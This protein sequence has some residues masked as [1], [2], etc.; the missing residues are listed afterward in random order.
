MSLFK[1]M[2]PETTDGKSRI[3]LEKSDTAKRTLVSH[4]WTDKTT[5]YQDATRVVD[6]VATVKIPL[7]YTTY[8]LANGDLI[9]SYHGKIS[10]EDY[11]KDAS[12]NSFRVVVKVNDV[13]KTEQDP[14]VGSGGDYTVN[15]S[16][17]EVTFLS[18]LTG[19][20]VVKVT[21]HHGGSG[22]YVIK[23]EAGKVLSIDV[24]EV[25]FATDVVLTDTMRFQP[26][27]YVDVFAPQLTPT[28]YPSGTLI[29]IAD[30]LVFK[31]FK[32]YMNDAVRSY[33]KYP[34]LGGAGW[35]GMNYETV[36]FDWDYVRS[37]ALISSY[38]M[39]IRL[40]PD[41]GNEFSGSYA[42]ATFYCAS[43]DE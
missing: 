1:V 32:D 29:P 24:V 2:T 22:T 43:E 23:P 31:T 4:D 33:P 36:V 11:L 28:P 38:G 19:S 18:A 3:A 35:R 6:E 27:G 16:A 42:T 14:A 8:T 7:V 34:A 40:T 9:D 15:Y 20:D 21:Y 41:I 13:V 17:G 10:Q 37:T 39:E 12:D 25:Q 26:Y 5:W 30:A